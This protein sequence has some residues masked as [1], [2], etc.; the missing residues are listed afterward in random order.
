MPALPRS[1][2]LRDGRVI[3]RACCLDDARLEARV[4]ARRQHARKKG[5]K[6]S[7]DSPGQKIATRK[8]EKTRRF[9]ICLAGRRGSNPRPP[10]SQAGKLT[11]KSTPDSTISMLEHATDIVQP[12]QRCHTKRDQRRAK[13]FV[14]ERRYRIEH[15]DKVGNDIRPFEAVWDKRASVLPP[16]LS[17][18]GVADFHQELPM[19]ANV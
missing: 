6:R 17:R 13:I 18:D 11:D 7:C 10:A 4:K 16:E 3:R 14:A 12:D 2:P 9:L 1:A 15:A 19:A 8:T 5:R